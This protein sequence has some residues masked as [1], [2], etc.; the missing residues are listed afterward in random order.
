MII[1]ENISNNITLCATVTL[2]R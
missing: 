2:H 1:G